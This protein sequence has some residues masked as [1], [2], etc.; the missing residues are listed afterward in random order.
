QE[1]R[2]IVKTLL[3]KKAAGNQAQSGWKST[4]W[5]AVATE[6]KKVAVGGGAEKTASKCSDHHSN[7]KSEYMQVKRLRG[8]SGFG[9]D[10]GRKL[11]VADDEHWN[12][13][14]KRDPNIGKWKTT[15]F[16]I[17]DEMNSLIDGVI[18]TG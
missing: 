6:L 7:L 1:D 16:P 5:S 8:M 14:K 11:V 15:L 17:Y 10:D 3:A 18:A 2:I 9:W 13:L 4:V 12:Q